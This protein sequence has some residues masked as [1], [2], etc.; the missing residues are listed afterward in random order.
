V[1]KAKALPALASFVEAIAFV[2]AVGRVSNEDCDEWVFGD[3]DNRLI[4]VCSL[5]SIITNTKVT[6]FVLIYRYVID[7]V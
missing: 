3:G 2:R 5:L 7:N 6:Q 1:E 4:G